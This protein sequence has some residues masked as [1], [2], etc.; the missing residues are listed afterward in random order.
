MK[1]SLGMCSAAA[2]AYTLGSLGNQAS[3][4]CLSRWLNLVFTFGSFWYMVT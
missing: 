2:V 1:E 3:A 4:F